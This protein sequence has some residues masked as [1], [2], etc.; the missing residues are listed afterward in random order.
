MWRLNGWRLDYLGH[1][2]T[3]IVWHSVQ[4]LFQQHKVTQNVIL[5]FLHSHQEPAAWRWWVRS[6]KPSVIGEQRYAGKS[7]LCYN[8]QHVQQQE[9]VELQKLC[10]AGEQ[11]H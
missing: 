1:G 3:S 8:P 11:S 6:S 9:L 10:Y 2:R 5:G 4:Q 7:H